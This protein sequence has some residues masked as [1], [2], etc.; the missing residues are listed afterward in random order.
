MEAIPSRRQQR[1]PESADHDLRPARQRLPKPEVR[2]SQT[3]LDPIENPR[4][5][6]RPLCEYCETRHN[7]QFAW[8]ARHGEGDDACR[9]SQK[10]A[11]DEERPFRT[12]AVR[13]L[14]SLI[15][16]LK[17]ASRR[18]ALELPPRLFQSL[19]HIR[20]CGQSRS[21]HYQHCPLKKEFL[22]H[23]F[24]YLIFIRPGK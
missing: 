21:N 18:Q 11:Y 24:K 7:D 4:G 12:A 3:Q 9:N 17:S 1:H 23:L 10:T 13:M 19:Q 6:H 16:L 5:A 2:S 20:N 15:G 22:I 8:N 14:P